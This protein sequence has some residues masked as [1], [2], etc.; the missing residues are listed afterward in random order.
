MHACYNNTGARAFLPWPQAPGTVRATRQRLGRRPGWPAVILARARA[1]ALRSEVHLV[2]AA[3]VGVLPQPLRPPARQL[4]REPLL[5]ALLLLTSAGVVPGRPRVVVVLEVHPAMLVQGCL[6]VLRQASRVE[7]RGLLRGVVSKVDVAAPREAHVPARGAAARVREGG[8]PGRMVGKVHLARLH[9][10]A[11][12]PVL[13]QQ[14][15]VGPRGPARPRVGEVHAAGGGLVASPRPA[16]LPGPRQRNL[17][18]HLEQS[19]VV[20]VA[21]LGERVAGRRVHAKQVRAFAAGRV[22][23]QRRR[24][25]HAAREVETLVQQPAPL[26]AAVDAEAA[27]HLRGGGQA[28]VDKRALERSQGRSPPLGVLWPQDLHVE[29]DHGV[30]FSAE[31]PPEG[32]A[33]LSTALAGGVN[34]REPQALPVRRLQEVPEGRLEARRA[35][36]S[37]EHA[38]ALLHHGDL[39]RAEHVAKRWPHL[40]VS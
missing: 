25:L 29:R 37:T 10:D 20:E 3:R 17:L 31:R 30:R 40:Q 39:I 1:T 16:H 36:P 34:H 6:N 28:P 24:L 9:V 12:V 22:L 13:R 4:R 32:Q 38:V 18:Q 8:L 15:G 26:G 7:A 27:H 11:L 35:G 5:E 2:A 14:T 19:L 23:P 33:C 21:D